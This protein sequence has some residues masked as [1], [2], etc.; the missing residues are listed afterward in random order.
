MKAI[1][2]RSTVL[3]AALT[4]FM[5]LSHVGC[6]SGPATLPA[7]QP[8]SSSWIELRVARP[9][10]PGTPMETTHLEV[11]SV[12]TDGLLRCTSYSY[13]TTTPSK[14]EVLLTSEGL[15]EIRS[16]LREAKQ[17]DVRL[18]YDAPN[19][20]LKVREASGRE[21]TYAA[22]TA[23]EGAIANRVL[24]KLRAATERGAGH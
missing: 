18:A 11:F 12:R 9:P 16:I 20:T 23:E 15:D 1:S 7:T 14:K 22:P 13:A 17:D 5:T 19:T 2:H 3:C 24:A 21:R 4:L 6:D 10:V 8:A